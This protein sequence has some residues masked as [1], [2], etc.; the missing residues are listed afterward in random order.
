MFKYYVRTD[1]KNKEIDY[2]TY[3]IAIIAVGFIWRYVIEPYIIDKPKS[4]PMWF[5]FKA[6]PDNKKRIKR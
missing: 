3:A 1:Y 2:K 4:K 5:L 6:P